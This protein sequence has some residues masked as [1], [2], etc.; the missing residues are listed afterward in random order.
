MVRLFRV[1]SLL[2]LTQNLVEL[3]QAVNFAR[4]KL[5]LELNLFCCSRPQETQLDILF[6]SVT[7][8]AHD[9]IL[10][11]CVSPFCSSTAVFDVSRPVFRLMLVSSQWL[12]LYTLTG[13]RTG[14]RSASQRLTVW[15][16]RATRYNE[17]RGRRCFSEW[18]Q[19][20]QFDYLLRPDIMSKLHDATSVRVADR[21]F[22][23]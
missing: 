14:D 5:T 12:W 10:F 1:R 7:S 2:K 19:C 4:Q 8:A 6:F 22:I 15:V 3:S 18:H 20:T 13:A 11:S 23:Y 9:V 21:S 17:D 16:H